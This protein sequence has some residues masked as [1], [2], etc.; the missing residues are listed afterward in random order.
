VPADTFLC[1]PRPPR[2]LVK[3]VQGARPTKGRHGQAGTAL[4][5]VILVPQVCSKSPMPELTRMD[6]PLQCSAYKPRSPPR[7]SA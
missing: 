5:V 1:Q 7:V 2:V 4:S 6:P 3:N